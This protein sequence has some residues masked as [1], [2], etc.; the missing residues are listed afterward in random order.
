MTFSKN[1]K[2][3]KYFASELL[4]YIVTYNPSMFIKDFTIIANMDCW[5]QIKASVTC[6]AG[7]TCLYSLS[8]KFKDSQL[9]C[10]FPYVFK[11]VQKMSMNTNYASLFPVMKSQC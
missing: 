11:D 4:Q 9:W 8:F 3:S 6:Y 7:S 1:V 2:F 5:L 10:V